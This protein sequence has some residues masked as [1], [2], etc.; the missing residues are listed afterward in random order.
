[1]TMIPTMGDQPVS[2]VKGRCFLERLPLLSIM[3]ED[4]QCHVLALDQ[5]QEFARAG[6]QLLLVLKRPGL[7][8]R[9][10]LGKQLRTIPL[11]IVYQP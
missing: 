1:M 8:F 11:W 10:T 4:D 3:T 6:T 7:S 2:F 5:V 9:E